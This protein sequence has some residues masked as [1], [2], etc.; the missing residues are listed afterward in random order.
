MKKLVLLM[1]GFGL[2][3]TSCDVDDDGPGTALYLAEVTEV[4]LPEFFE[5]GETYEIDVTY[6]LPTACHQ[7]A[8]I[9]VERGGNSGDTYRDIYIVGMAT[10]AADLEEC[11]EEG[12]DLE[13]TNS[14]NL[15]IDVNESYTFYLWEGVDDDEE[16]IYTEIEVPV[17]EPDD[18]EDD[19][20]EETE[21]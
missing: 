4:D 16:N 9:R 20:G 13:K 5:E 1:M 2:L 18:S 12:G 7:D 11:D 8:G 3:F 6:L 19:T 15:T 21:E 14:F 10:A 17:G